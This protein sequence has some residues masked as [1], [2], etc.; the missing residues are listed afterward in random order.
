MRDKPQKTVSTRL[1]GKQTQAGGALPQRGKC[2]A[3]G[4]VFPSTIDGNAEA[5][6]LIRRLL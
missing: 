4:T 3:F 2:G 5:V 1:D 6:R